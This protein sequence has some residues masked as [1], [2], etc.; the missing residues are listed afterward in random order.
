MEPEHLLELNPTELVSAGYAAFDE[1]KRDSFRSTHLN[2]LND[3]GLLSQ[4]YDGS[5]HGMQSLVRRFSK[6]GRDGGCGDKSYN[7]L[8]NIDWVSRGHGC[9]S[10]HSQIFIALASMNGVFAREV[11]HKLHTF[12]EYW[13]SDLMKWVWIDPQFAIMARTETGGYMSFRELKENI[14]VGSIIE[15]DFFG[16]TKHVF[17]SEPVDSSPYYKPEAFQS[18]LMTNGNNVFGENDWA[19]QFSFLPKSARQ[20]ILL[21]TGVQPGYL[22]WEIDSATSD[23]FHTRQKAHWG[24]IAG[25]LIINL[26]A[27]VMIL[28]R[29][30]PLFDASINFAD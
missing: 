25:F 3:M 6:N 8:E 10:D 24:F 9:C 21:S 18:I 22:Y 27:I 30:K 4:T 20:L 14:S 2:T 17:A 5:A 19:I 1:K 16:S 26:A 13:D 15:W 12:N 7:L 28:R 11:H 23:S 29:S